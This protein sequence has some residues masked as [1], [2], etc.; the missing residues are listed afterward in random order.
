MKLLKKAKQES[1]Q[2][3]RKDNKK[4]KSK[5][6]EAAMKLLKKLSKK[7]DNKKKQSPGGLE[8][9]LKERFRA[10]QSQEK[11]AKNDDYEWQ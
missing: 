5:D 2:E 9:A 8:K 1:K 3:S 11:L 7:Q 4:P 10:M 6:L